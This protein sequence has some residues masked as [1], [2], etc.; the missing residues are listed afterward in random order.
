MYLV[1][2][3]VILWLLAYAIFVNSAYCLKI[4]MEDYRQPKKMP[5]IH[6]VMFIAGIVMWCLASVHLG[7]VI[8]QVTHVVTP[9]PNAQAQASIATTQVI[10]SLSFC[11]FFSDCSAVHDR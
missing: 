5:M 11:I 2:V 1:L 4:L 9:I 7:L 8:Q 10:R 6:R 3:L